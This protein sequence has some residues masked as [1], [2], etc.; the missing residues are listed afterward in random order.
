MYLARLKRFDS[1]LHFVVTLTEDRA[2]TQ[3]KEVDREITAGRYR[4]PLHGIRWGAKDVLA[5]RN[6]PTTW[7]A[8]GFEHQMIDQDA[9]VVKRLD[10]AGAILVAKL[11]TGAL[12]MGDKWFGGQTRNPWNTNQGSSGSSAGPAAATAS[13]CVGFAIGTEGVGSISSPSTR[14]GASGYRPTYGFVPHS[15]AMAVVWTMI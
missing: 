4:G 6:Y 5:V 8:A 2:R 10:A 9:T 11:T 3:A 1:R 15:G 13:G 7:G 12:A 14:C